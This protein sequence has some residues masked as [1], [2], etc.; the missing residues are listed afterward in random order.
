L[1]G[2]GRP[3]RSDRGQA[4]GGR[5]PDAH[6]ERIRNPREGPRIQK[7]NLRLPRRHF[8]EV[9]LSLFLGVC[10]GNLRKESATPKV[11]VCAFGAASAPSTATSRAH[12]CLSSVS[13][14][15]WH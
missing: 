11:P 4:G 7:E 9:K 13:Q 8:R 3:H 6:P 10:C 2:V 15:R 12:F 5:S 1:E 14:D